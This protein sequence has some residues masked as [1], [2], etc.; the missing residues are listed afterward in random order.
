[1]EFAKLV[2]SLCNSDLLQPHTLYEKVMREPIKYLFIYLL[3]YYQTQQDLFLSQTV[4][5]NS[6]LKK[7]LQTLVTIKDSV[8]WFR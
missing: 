5:T 8:N 7:E 4:K 1:M 6:T 2:P 3:T